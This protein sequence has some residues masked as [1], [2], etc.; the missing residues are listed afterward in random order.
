MRLVDIQR[1]LIRWEPVRNLDQLIVHISNSI[2]W[3]FLHCI[4]TVKK[5]GGLPAAS[6]Y[7]VINI[8]KKEEIFKIGPCGTPILKLL[9]DDCLF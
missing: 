9:T 8:N 1:A 4:I 7:N 6:V 5:D 2:I 3:I